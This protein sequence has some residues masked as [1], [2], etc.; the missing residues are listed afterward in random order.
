MQRDWAHLRCVHHRFGSRAIAATMQLRWRYCA[1]ATIAMTISSTWTSCVV[2][3]QE[4]VTRATAPSEGRA[5]CMLP[6]RVVHQTTSASCCVP[7][8]TRVRHVALRATRRTSQNGMRTWVPSATDSSA[9]RRSSLRRCDPTMRC[10]PSY[11]RTAPTPRHSSSCPPARPSLLRSHHSSLRCL[12]PM[13]RR[14]SV[15]S[16]WK[17][18]SNCPLSGRRAACAPSTRTACAGY[19]PAPCAA[20]SCVTRRRSRRATRS[21]REPSLLPMRSTPPPRRGGRTT[22]CA[23]HATTSARSSWPSAEHTGDR[24]SRRALEWEAS[25]RRWAPILD[26]ALDRTDLFDADETR[27]QRKGVG[28]KRSAPRRRR[29]ATETHCHFG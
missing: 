18:S 5:C 7:A 6:W 26:G 9:F 25:T 10:V 19:P 28:T 11:S 21:S 2:G 3:A 12:V 22:H 8:P 27:D 4:G 24:I 16:A 1:I 23:A 29:R 20:P 14:S 15:Q 17:A 13:A